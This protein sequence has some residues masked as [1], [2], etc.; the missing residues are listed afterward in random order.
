MSAADAS[1]TPRK[2][3]TLVRVTLG[4]GYERPVYIHIFADH[5]RAR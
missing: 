3:Q 4:Q 5:Y 2:P 1:M